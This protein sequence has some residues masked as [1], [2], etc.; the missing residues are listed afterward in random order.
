MTTRDGGSKDIMEPNGNATVGKGEAAPSVSVVVATRDRPELLREAIASILG[1]D[2]EGHIEILVV[3]DRCEPDTSLEMES[4][5]R[6]V[7]VLRNTRTPGLPGAR[8]SGAAEATGDLLAFATTTSG[9][10]RR[11]GCR[12]STC[13]GREPTSRQRASW[14]TTTAARCPE[15]RP[16]RS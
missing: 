12:S 15:S 16:T 4:G 7:R 13:S 14:S 3:H 2:Y 8:N 1:Q 10:P 11:P 6:R 9:F 5:N